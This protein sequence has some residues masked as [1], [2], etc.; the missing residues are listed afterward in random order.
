MLMES[1]SSATPTSFSVFTVSASIFISQQKIFL[2]VSAQEDVALLLQ[3]SA[4]SS[5]SSELL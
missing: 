3:E 1:P 5:A 2:H 4:N